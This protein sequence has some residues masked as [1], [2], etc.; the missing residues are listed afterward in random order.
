[1]SRASKVTLGIS[2]LFATGCIL[3]VHYMQ[4]LDVKTR[5]VGIERDDARRSDKRIENE[6]E[7]LRQ[8]E[9]RRQLEQSQVVTGKS[10]LEQNP[11]PR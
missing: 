4:E 3:G 8:E 2:T 9:L 11:P 7:M 10:Y 6:L 5:R 1:M